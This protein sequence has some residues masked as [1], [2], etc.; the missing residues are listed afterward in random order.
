MRDEVFVESEGE[1]GG[2]A[3]LD[4]EE[5]GARLVDVDPSVEV[6]KA[7]AEGGAAAL[8]AKIADVRGDAFEVARHEALGPIA[9]EDADLGGCEYFRRQGVRGEAAGTKFAGDGLRSVRNPEIRRLGIGGRTRGV[10]QGN[11][12]APNG[13]DFDG[14]APEGLGRIHKEGGLI[15]GCMDEPEGEPLV[16]KAHGKLGGVAAFGVLGGDLYEAEGVAFG[17]DEGVA[18]LLIQRDFALTNEG[19]LWP[20]RIGLCVQKSG[21]CIQKDAC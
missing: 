4:G 16:A 18:N 9:A 5:V 1:G 12:C 17:E 8:M 20:R 7:I 19:G 6:G 15:G 10:G 2:T 13:I 14:I 3:R 11:I 21:L